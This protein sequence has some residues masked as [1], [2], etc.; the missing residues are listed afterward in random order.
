MNDFIQLFR[1][2]KLNIV[3]KK[4]L[5]LVT[6][7]IFSAAILHAQ[8]VSINT[9]G[10]APNAS[11]L[12]DV[13]STNKGMLVPRMTSAQRTTISSPAPGLLVF[14]NT[15]E[16][17]WFYTTSGWTELIAGNSQW[18]LDGAGNI[19][20]NNP[21]SVTVGSGITSGKFNVN[22]SSGNAIANFNGITDNSFI[23]F[24]EKNIYRGYVGSYAGALSDMDFGTGSGNSTG[25]IHFTLQGNPSLTLNTAGNLGMGTTSPTEKLELS[26]GNILLSNSNLGIRLNAADRPMI[27]RGWNP[28]TSGPYAGIGRWGLFKEPNNLVFGIPG[29]VTGSAFEFAGWYP[30][31]GRLLLILIDVSGKMTRPNTNSADLL[32]IAY[33]NVSSTGTI[34]TGTGN[35]IVAKVG[36]GTYQIKIPGTTY[37]TTHYTTLVT[38]SG[39]IIS[40][41]GSLLDVGTPGTNG[42]LVII[43]NSTGAVDA[44]FSFLVYVQ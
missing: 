35:F 4:I 32:P 36:V 21:G 23:T 44:S 7:T 13:K 17:F 39:V 29:D 5:T 42:V 6:A 1:K 20:N 2:K 33:G 34:M 16:S 38:V 30:N 41:Y 15:T 37:S 26:S 14:D 22:S 9:D 10:S 18:N 27:T 40:A 12:L 31:A 25:K 11:A 3:I 43:K 8:S 24:Y 19:S 28:F